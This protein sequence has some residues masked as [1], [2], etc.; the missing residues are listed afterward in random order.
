[1]AK[2]SDL[3]KLW[4]ARPRCH[5]ALKQ[6]ETLAQVRLDLM[7]DPAER[8]GIHPQRSFSPFRLNGCSSPG[9]PR[10][11]AITPIDVAKMSANGVR[12]TVTGGAQ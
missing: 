12:D 3:T 7:A 4:H 2:D 10:G 6:A 9:R 11:P 5:L 8:S 1:M